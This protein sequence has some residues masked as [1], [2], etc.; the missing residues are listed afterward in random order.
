MFRLPDAPPSR[1]PCL[2]N[3][4]ANLSA[5]VGHVLRLMIFWAYP[6][7][8]PGQV[9]PLSRAGLAGGHQVYEGHQTARYCPAPGFDNQVHVA[10]AHET[11]PDP[12]P[13]S[14]VG[15]VTV[16]GVFVY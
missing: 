12:T 4:D 2:E 14:A 16:S 9:V 13:G 11:N 6:N 15:A 10:L 8:Y 7:H 3:V 1:R 5:S